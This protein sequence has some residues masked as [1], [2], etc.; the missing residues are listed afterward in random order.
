VKTSLF[1][2][3]L[4]AGCGG[5]APQQK[6]HAPL[7]A[8]QPGA[9]QPQKPPLERAL[10]ELAGSDYRA[11]EALFREAG[12]GASSAPASLG[13]AE[14]YLATG[15]YGDAVTLARS[16]AGDAAIGVKAAVVEAKALL[17]EGKLEQA[18]AALGRVIADERASDARLLLGELLIESGRRSDAREPLFALIEEYNE[19]KLAEGD[20]RALTRVGRAAELLRSPRDAN[21]AYAE[22]E[23]TG[24]FN[25]EL[26]L[27]RAAL[28]LEKYDPGQAEAVLETLLERAPNHP[29][30]LVLMAR[31][32]LDQ[33]LD[34]DEAERL[35]RQAL[36]QNPH[37]PS[38][39]M[40]LAGISL[41][42]M[43]LEA[44]S[45]FIEQ[46]LAINPRFLPLLSMRASIPFLEG[47]ERAFRERQAEVLRFNR[48]Y[49]RFFEIVGEYAEWEHRYDEIVD[50]MREG[51]ALDSEDASSLAALGINLI[52]AGKDDDGVAALSRA[53][54]LDPYNVRI[55]NTLNLF[56]KVI[57][58]EYVNVAGTRFTVRYH[59]DDKALL[60]RYVPALLE[61]A[62]K[63]MVAHYGFSPEV[64][65]G[66]EL[67]ADREHFA[68]RTSGLPETAI[69]GV[70]FGHT[71]A[72]MSPQRETFNLGMTLFHELAHVFH[73]QQSKRRVPRWFTE[74]LAEYETILARPEWIREQDPELFEL[75]R[76]GRLPNFAAMSR[77]FT[78]AEQLSDVATAYYASSQMV[79]MLGETHGMPKLGQMLKLWGEG[80][81][82][83]QVF[84]GALGHASSVEDQRFAVR[85]ERVFE[86]YKGKFVPVSRVG[87]LPA[88]EEAAK[89]EPK[90]AE[91]RT[92]LALA[93]IREGEGKR[94]EAELRAALAIDAKFADA[95][96]LS[97]KL[98]MARRE[99]KVAER[100][101][102]SMLGDGQDGYEVQMLL[103][104][105]AEA[106]RD[107]ATRNAALL[108]AR[109]LDPTQ[110]DPLYGLLREAEQRKDAEA[111]LGLLR[112][113]VKL[114]EHDAS[115][116]RELVE[117]LVERGEFAEAVAVGEGAIY[118]DV[119]GFETHFAFA[120][121]LEQTGDLKRA[122][123]ELESAL[124]CQP[125]PP[126]R[127]EATKRLAA[128]YKKLGRAKD[129]AA[130]EKAPVPPKPAAP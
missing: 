115:V 97:A 1:L 67:Y 25:A 85:L 11:A 127:A 116:F 18:E 41:R 27:Y 50:L 37:L 71:L 128:L 126:Q 7:A 62:W 55:F 12:A 94:A 51:V 46:G 21:E 2:V 56:E 3:L 58:A 28:F 35:A 81:T 48:E 117:R 59:K 32:R 61:R 102:R 34:F 121:A 129:A 75:R 98:A 22:A 30:A 74:G 84:Q 99:P 124:L 88:A 36:G 66:V 93:L 38:A 122:A 5:P 47:N 103:A 105:I 77:A 123:F 13:L 23:E 73:I 110:V 29:D 107:A 39:F 109:K 111:S 76:A 8:A 40:V 118:V 43:E 86:R 63:T 53:F 65:V 90:S 100:V 45:R 82:T 69:Q 106:N 70:C 31:V 14:V 6:P 4:L 96:F 16:L 15:R 33:S 68:I 52:R 54:A 24:V 108:A 87:A 112:E 83:E 101:V 79:A 125:E 64:P 104:E 120:A 9:K 17:A 26:L 20:A 89:R 91:K 80:K 44:A 72:S 19:G 92:G 10:D 95:R 49:S 60:E 119:T 130:L 78:R 42:D 114:S 113:L 57:P